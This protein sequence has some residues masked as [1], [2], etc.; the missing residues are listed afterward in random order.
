MSLKRVRCR[1]CGATI[2]WAIT[3][4]GKKRMPVD[5]DQDDQRGN[6]ALTATQSDEFGPHWAAV[7]VPTNKAAAMRAAG[8]PLHLPHHASCPDGE[9]WKK[10]R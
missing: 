9:K 4:P 5:A 3:Q 8:Q 1:S 6:V 7:V 10:K 2:V